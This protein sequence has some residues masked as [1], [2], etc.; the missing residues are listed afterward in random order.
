M[1]DS[2]TPDLIG[3]DANGWTKIE[4]ADKKAGPV[5][6]TDGGF[7]VTGFWQEGL[8]WMAGWNTDQMHVRIILHPTHFRPLPDGP[9]NG[10]AHGE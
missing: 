4:E 7:Y 8:G 2:V 10:S 3:P 5:V 9:V 6:L 1:V